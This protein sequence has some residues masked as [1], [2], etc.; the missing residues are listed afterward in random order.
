[1][2]RSIFGLTACGVFGMVLC[3]S[4]LT[5][6]A[7][8]PLDTRERARQ[9][10]ASAGYGSYRISLRVEYRGTTCFQQLEVRT[11]QTPRSIRNTCEVVWLNV[12]SVPE[13]FDLARQIESVPATRCMPSNLACICQRVFSA[14]QI[15]YDEQLG[16]PTLVL[17]RSYVRPNWAGVGFWENLITNGG[18][19]TCGGPAPRRLTI[20]VLGLS[21][22][23]S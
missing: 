2:Q 4:L 19:P 7:T 16:Y 18:S 20:Q 15:D 22:I 14:R 1:M 6:M 23:S 11:G 21:Q 17:S 12:L 3:L 5:A 8:V 9:R 13:L 10:W